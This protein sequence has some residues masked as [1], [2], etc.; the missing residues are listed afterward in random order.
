MLDVKPVG[1]RILVEQLEN[2][3]FGDLVLPDNTTMPGVFRFIVRDLGEPFILNS[4]E[5][6]PIT[7][8]VGEY[9][10]F[11]ARHL[12]PCGPAELY[13][14]RTLGILPVD[15]IIGIVTGEI[16][17]PKARLLHAREFGKAKLAKADAGPKLVVH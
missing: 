12:M 2:R 13:G 5:R 4:G 9:V 17:P 3:Q 11:D 10:I 1:Y 16:D 15:A 14:G 7:I 8:K 6:V